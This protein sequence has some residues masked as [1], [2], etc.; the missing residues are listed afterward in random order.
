MQL[1]YSNVSGIQALRKFYM[2]LASCE[3]EQSG[4]W[5]QS[6]IHC[7]THLQIVISLYYMSCLILNKLRQQENTTRIK[8]NQYW[9]RTEESSHIKVLGRLFLTV[10]PCDF[11]STI[12]VDEKWSLPK[13]LLYLKLCKSTTSTCHRGTMAKRILRRH[14]RSW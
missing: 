4:S 1:W 5:E 12:I 11:Y 14:V 3:K 8:S 2:R 7:C 10:K 6:I 13:I 9:F